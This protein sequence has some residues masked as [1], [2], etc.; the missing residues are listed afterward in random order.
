M[1]LLNILVMFISFFLMAKVVDDLFVPTLDVISNKLKLT[2]SVAGATIMAMGTS[3]PELSTALLALFL[4]N[5]NP[6]T[7]VGTIVGSAIFQILVVIG[8]AALIKTSY[9]NWKP[10]IRDGIFYALSILVLII[11]VRDGTFTF[12]EASLFVVIYILYL[13]VL[14]VWTRLVDESKEPNP[15]DFLGH[16]EE[17]KKRS[18]FRR[19]K[20]IVLLFVR[21]VSRPVNKLFSVF[22]DPREHPNSTVPLFIFSLLSIGF[23]S[24]WLVLSSE[25]IA[26]VLGIPPA[27]V[28][29]TVLAGGSSIPELIGSA[30]V[31]REG[32]GDMAI[33]NAIGSNIFDILI[34][35]GFP[36]FLYTLFKGDLTDVGD[37][38][39]ISSILL[40]FATLISVLLLLASQKFKIGRLFGLLLLALYVVY[41]F[42]AYTGMI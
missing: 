37:P 5:T 42:A 23:M 40:L 22:P 8:F 13:V 26:L 12:T 2:P 19:E 34:S 25:N 7:G 16:R 10:V 24:Y 1:I 33:S 17:E 32:R 15:V 39:I 14:F 11:F 36:V 6:A 31:S 4:P 28:A 20:A 30:I 9:L 3:A 41:V 35:L 38:N 29:L 21:F 18:R 27:I